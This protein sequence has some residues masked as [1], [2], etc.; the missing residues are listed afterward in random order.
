MIIGLTGSMGCGKSTVAQ[1][2]TELGAYLLDSDKLAREV[3]AV[4]S[5]GLKETVKKFG[6]TILTQQGE[7]D[8]KEMGKV[9]SQDPENR[10]ALEQIIHPRIRQI[11]QIRIDKWQSKDPNC[12]IILDIPLLFETEAQKRCD[13]VVVVSCGNQ[14][15]LRIKDRPMDPELRK[16]LL[17]RQMPEAEKIKQADWVVDNGGDL[18][19]TRRQVHLVWDALMKIM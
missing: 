2:F 1:L 14:Q 10:K 7:L 4:G 13:K 16:K 19:N 9:V 6:P 8:R 5:D 12:I 11:Q 17:A 3:V 18:E 15:A